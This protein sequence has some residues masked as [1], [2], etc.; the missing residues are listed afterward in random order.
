MENNT[1][2]ITNYANATH[3]KWKNRRVIV[4]DVGDDYGLCFKILAIK[5]DANTPSAK[6]YVFKDRLKIT[7]IRLSPEA[8]ISL[9]EA[10]RKRFITRHQL[11]K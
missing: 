11:D 3:V 4:E 1:G 8:A 6:H 9:Y 10:L 5:E 7:T 2:T